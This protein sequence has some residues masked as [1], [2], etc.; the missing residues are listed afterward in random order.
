MST[1]HALAK[2]ARDAAPNDD[3]WSD[4]RSRRV[5]ASLVTRQEKRAQRA[6]FLRRGAGVTSAAAVIVFALLRGATAAPSTSASSAAPVATQETV[7]ANATNAT[8]AELLA[9]SDRAGD[10]GFGRD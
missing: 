4:D 9:A 10:G 3:V 6:R 1:L 2:A 8:N 7:A 5:L